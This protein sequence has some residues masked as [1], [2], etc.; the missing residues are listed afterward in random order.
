MFRGSV[1]GTGYLLHSPISPSLPLPCIAVCHLISTGLYFSPYII[2][3]INLS[4]M[5]WFGAWGTCRGEERCAQLF[6]WGKSKLAR[7]GHRWENN[8]KTRLEEIIWVGVEWINLAQDR[9]KWR[10]VVDTVMN[11]SVFLYYLRYPWP[12]LKDS[13][14]LVVD[15]ETFGMIRLYRLFD[16]GCHLQQIKTRQEVSLTWGLIR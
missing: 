13:V 8:F 16:T 14:V 5:A 7:P 4:C 15:N 12:Y 2:R 10:A 1:K 3:L 6:W 9:G 11:F